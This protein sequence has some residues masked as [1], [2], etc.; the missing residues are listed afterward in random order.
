MRKKAQVVMLPTEKASF[1]HLGLN[2]W[3]N[4]LYLVSITQTIPH[5]P[6]HLYFTTDEEIKEGDWCLYQ[7]EEDTFIGR[8]G[9]APKEA[10][11][12]TNDE[13][14]FLVCDEDSKNLKKIVA[15][16]N[17]DLWYFRKHTIVSSESIYS[18]VQIIGKI[19]TDFIEA[20]VREQGKIT[21]VMLE[22]EAY[23]IKRATIKGVT[24]RLF[25]P[26]FMLP[27]ILDCKFRLK[28]R[29]NGSVIVHPVK[30][31]VWNDEQLKNRIF[32]FVQYMDGNGMTGTLRQTIE[33]WFDKNYPQ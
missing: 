13:G 23:D 21:E 6:Q 27:P 14:T 22:Y 16:T 32:E 26:E 25:T 19:P 4:R 11:L 30:E 8:M 7:D 28:L 2:E 17:P 20:Y 24:F 5:T 33:Q 3:N 15:S 1:P 29:N 9:I 18:A 12:L 10:P 31:R